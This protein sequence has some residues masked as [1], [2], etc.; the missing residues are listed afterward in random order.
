M[1]LEIGNVNLAQESAG[2]LG[3]EVK[4]FERFKWSRTGLLGNSLGRDCEA[5]RKR[6]YQDKKEKF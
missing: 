2:K 4:F 6:E 1:E 5:G 3:F